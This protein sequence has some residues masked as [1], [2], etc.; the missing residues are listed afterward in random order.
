MY[1]LVAIRINTAPLIFSYMKIECN[2][3]CEVHVVESKN[4]TLFITDLSCYLLCLPLWICIEC[5]TFLIVVQSMVLE[6]KSLLKSCSDLIYI[7]GSSRAILATAKPSCTLL[8]MADNLL[9]PQDTLFSYDYLHHCQLI[10][11]LLSDLLY[12]L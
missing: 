9:F 3:N 11:N 2:G 1:L 7:E 4:F 6:A 10:P 12:D 8:V 5:K